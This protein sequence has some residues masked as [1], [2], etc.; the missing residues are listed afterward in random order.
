[1]EWKTFNEWCVLKERNLANTEKCED[2]FFAYPKS[3]TSNINYY[4]FF[5]IFLTQFFPSLTA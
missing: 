3:F 5:L 1:M 4:C 2:F